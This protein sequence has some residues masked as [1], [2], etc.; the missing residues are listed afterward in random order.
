MLKGVVNVRRVTGNGGRS[1]SAVANRSIKNVRV[2]GGKVSK[3]AWV[4]TEVFGDDV[5]WGVRQPI[6]DHEGSAGR[7]SD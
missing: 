7:V 5:S 3:Q 6:V 1:D 4:N 2:G